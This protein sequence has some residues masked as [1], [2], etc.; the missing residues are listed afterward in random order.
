MILSAATVSFLCYLPLVYFF[1]VLLRERGEIFSCAVNTACEMRSSTRPA[2]CLND[3]V[4]AKEGVNADHGF[5]GSFNLVV[6]G[7]AVE[8]KVLFSSRL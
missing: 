6:V 2:T 4:E 8:S 7:F 3:S 5:G 1:L